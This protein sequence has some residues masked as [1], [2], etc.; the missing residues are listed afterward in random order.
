MFKFCSE[1]QVF[2]TLAAAALL[3]I[4]CALGHDLH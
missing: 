2:T 3:V 1:H 4:A